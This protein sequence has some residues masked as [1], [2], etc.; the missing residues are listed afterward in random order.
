MNLQANV[1]ARASE[2]VTPLMVAAASGHSSCIE[3]LA[4]RGAHVAAATDCGVTALMLAAAT[5]HVNCIIS[6]LALGADIRAVN[7]AGWT[8]LR[9]AVHNMRPKC[10]AALGYRSCSSLPGPNSSRR[11]PGN[12]ESGSSGL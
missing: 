10:I 4:A 7:G 2:G 9:F 8:A 6:L 3:A 5:G 11:P 12:G 1:N